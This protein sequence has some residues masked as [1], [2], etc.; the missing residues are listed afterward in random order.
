MPGGN[1][2][3][4]EKN[5]RLKDSILQRNRRRNKISY[6][7]GRI[8]RLVTRGQLICVP[9]V[10]RHLVSRYLSPDMLVIMGLASAFTVCMPEIP[11]TH[12]RETDEPRLMAPRLLFS[13][14]ISPLY[15]SWI[16]STLSSFLL[17][18]NQFSLAVSRAL[19]I[20]CLLF[21]I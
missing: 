18:I 7:I 3:G 19:Y 20:Y 11:G 5:E 14:I 10:L 13:P 6:V 21:L 4:R 16:S 17:F 9:C 2:P 15:Y 8:E 12:S 1:W